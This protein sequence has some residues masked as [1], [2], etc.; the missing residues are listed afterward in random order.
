MYYVLIYSI[1][2]PYNTY[3]FYV[4]YECP[5]YVSY[6]GNWH[7]RVEHMITSKQMLKTQEIIEKEYIFGKK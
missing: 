7:Y 4:F 2:P 5:F 3:V 1:E 6:A